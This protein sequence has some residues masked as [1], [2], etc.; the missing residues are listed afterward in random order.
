MHSPL[1]AQF[2]CCI[3]AVLN[4]WHSPVSPAIPMYI[5]SDTN[6]LACWINSA[7]AVTTRGGWRPCIA[8]DRR[9]MMD[10]WYNPKSASLFA[11]LLRSGL[12]LVAG[13]L[14][15]L[16]WV[17]L[18]VL[19]YCYA[20]SSGFWM[21]SSDHSSPQGQVVHVYSTEQAIKHSYPLTH[22]RSYVDCIA[23]IFVNCSSIAGQETLIWHD[24]VR[25]CGTVF[26]IFVLDY[27]LYFLQ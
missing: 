3:Y 20:G 9:S 7:S 18:S 25:S 4:F 6:A 2:P 19:T 21:L 15:P 24:N 10:C 8:T 5:H 23:S 22:L 16:Y 26:V 1:S 11:S 12:S 27:Y 14:I 17:L 13:H